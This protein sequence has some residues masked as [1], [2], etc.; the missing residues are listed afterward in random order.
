MMAHNRLI[1]AVFHPNKIVYEVS[2]YFHPETAVWLKAEAEIKNLQ[3]H[4]LRLPFDLSVAVDTV[5]LSVPIPQEL[6]IRQ[7]TC[8]GHT[9]QTEMK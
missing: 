8:S 3:K 2:L 5:S 7:D 4:Q 1:R 6:E 9:I